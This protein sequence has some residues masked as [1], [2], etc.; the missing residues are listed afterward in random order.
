MENV[1]EMRYYE[2]GEGLLIDR[3]IENF[4]DIDYEAKY[5]VLRADHYGVPQ[6]RKRLF[7]IG[8]RLKNSISWPKNTHEDSEQPSLKGLPTESVLDFR[9]T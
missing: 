3:I 9:R 4:R 1:S 7:I 6:T 5:N 2:N 8:N